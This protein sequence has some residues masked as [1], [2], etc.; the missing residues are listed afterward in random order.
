VKRNAVKSFVGLSI[1]FCGLTACGGGDENQSGQKSEFQVSPT[2]A[3][4]SSGDDFCP[5]TDS[6]AADV[7]VIGGTA[8][9]RVTSTF[10]PA[11]KF[12]PPGSATPT[13]EG[14]YTVSNLNGQFAVFVSGCLDMPVTVMDYLGRVVTVQIKAAS[15]AGD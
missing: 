9:Y 14:T 12:G 11:I 4:L 6:R 15:G 7:H 10:Y 5:D 2:E 13:N 8:P 1:L 3:T